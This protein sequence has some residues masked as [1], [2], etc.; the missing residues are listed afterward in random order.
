MARPEI[1]LTDQQKEIINVNICYKS[2][3]YISRETGLSKYIIRKF[4]KAQ[5]ELD[6]Q[7][8]QEQVERIYHESHETYL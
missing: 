7:H 3:N 8:F 4:L 2:M 6:K 1:E 5:I